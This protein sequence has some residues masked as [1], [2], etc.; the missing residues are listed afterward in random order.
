M[1]RL[2]NKLNL[3]AS[4]AMIHKVIKNESTWEW[5]TGRLHRDQAHY[6]LR[7]H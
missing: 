7:Y 3:T 6:Q 4:T 1:Q 5:N 2:K